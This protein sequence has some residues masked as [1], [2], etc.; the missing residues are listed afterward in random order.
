MRVLGLSANGG[1]QIAK[2]ISNFA[3]ELDTAG[4][5]VSLIAKEVQY[6]SAILNDLK[7]HLEKLEAKRLP[8]RLMKG[9]RGR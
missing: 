9:T 2:G 8:E 5:Q 3:S 6:V 1:L 4:E 7:G